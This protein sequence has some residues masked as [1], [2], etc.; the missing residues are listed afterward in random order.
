LVCSTISGHS[1]GVQ[2]DAW[3]NVKEVEEQVEMDKLPPK[4]KSALVAKAGAG[5]ITAVELLTKKN[6][7]VAY[8]AQ[9]HTNGKKSEVQVGPT[10]ETLD[11]EE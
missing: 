2:I 1:K 5:K 11:H 6:K 7:L 9:V 8:E 3:G 4:V 10:G